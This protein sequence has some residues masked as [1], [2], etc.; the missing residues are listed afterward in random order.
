M[1]SSSTPIDL[2]EDLR[3]GLETAAGEAGKTPTDI[4]VEALESFGVKRLSEDQFQKRLTGS[5]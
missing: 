2:P 3:R 1:Q 4:V 5:Q